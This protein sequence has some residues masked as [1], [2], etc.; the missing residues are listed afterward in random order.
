M[1][2]INQTLEC[3]LNFAVRTGENA[4]LNFAN[5]VKEQFVVIFDYNLWISLLSEGYGLL[6]E[7]VKSIFN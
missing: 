5:V 7:L 6:P 3:S 4:E 1:E 2:V